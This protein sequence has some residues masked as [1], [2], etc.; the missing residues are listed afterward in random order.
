M[1]HGTVMV[2]DDDALVRDT[3][4]EILAE[5]GIAAVGARHGQEALARL[6]GDGVRPMVILLDLMMPVMNGWE[7][8]AEQ[9]SDPSLAAIPVVV[10]SASDPCGI[11]ADVLMHKPF[12][13]PTL[14]QAV[15]SLAPALRA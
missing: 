8:R 14:V 3:V 6:R 7:F 12:A 11:S 10:M 2:V 13:V 1:A 15:V 5:E 4:I 9:L